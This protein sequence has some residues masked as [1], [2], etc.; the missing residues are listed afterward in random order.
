VLTADHETGGMAI[1][2][3]ARDGSNMK[4]AFTTKK[5]TPVLV[6]VLAY[7]PGAE[8]FAGW[9]DNTDIPLRMAELWALPLR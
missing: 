9:M 5:H 4:F 2:S 7:G 3:G 1:Q 6:P 8:R